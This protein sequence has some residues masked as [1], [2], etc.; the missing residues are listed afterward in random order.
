MGHE[1]LRS[2]LGLSRESRRS[3]NPVAER[4]VQGSEVWHRAPN[5]GTVACSRPPQPIRHEAA[6]RAEALLGR[7]ATPRQDPG[8]STRAAILASSSGDQYEIR[9]RV[10]ADST[11]F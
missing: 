4:C 10:A 8:T 2:T 9:D 1:A 11:G 3:G 5:R 6:E 7:N